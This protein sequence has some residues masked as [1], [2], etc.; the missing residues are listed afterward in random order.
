MQGNRECI[1]L[2]VDTSDG[3][4][5]LSTMLLKSHHGWVGINKQ[6]ILHGIMKKSLGWPNDF[7]RDQL[8]DGSYKGIPHSKSKHSG[9]VAPEVIDPWALRIAS[10]IKRSV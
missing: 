7:F 9:V 4:A 6:V 1:L 10:W 8:G 5:K 2:E 3:A